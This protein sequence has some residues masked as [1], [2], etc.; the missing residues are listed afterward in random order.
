[1]YILGIAGG[2]DPIHQNRYG[3]DDTIIHD[4]AAVLL[5][6]DDIIA[7]IEEERLNRIKHTNK[8]PAQ[9]IRFCLDRADVTLDE[10]DAVAFYATEE[11]L[12]ASLAMFHLH[13]P[14]LG[15]FV[16]ART[17]ILQL[18]EEEAGLRLRK[19]R[20]QFVPHHLAHALSAY[21]TSGFDDC[22]ILSIDGAGEQLS[23]LVLEVRDGTINELSAKGISDSLG[24]LYMDVIRFLGYRMYDEY[25]VMG[26]SPYGDPEPFRDLFQTFYTLAPDGDFTIHRDRILEL[27]HRLKPRKRGELFLQIHKD[28]AAALQESVEI[29]AFH[30][31]THHRMAAGLD[32]LALTGGVA[33]NSSMNGKII[34]SGLFR[35]VYVPPAAG[36]SGC[37]FGAAFAAYHKAKSTLPSKRLK[38]VY[39]GTHVGSND[40][41]ESELKRW[42]PLIRFS[43]MTDTPVETARRLAEGSVIGWVQGEAEFGP[44]ALG[45]RSIV[46][47]PRPAQNKEIINAMI[48]KR[49]AY[50][51]F[52]PSVLLERVKDFFET[53]AQGGEFPF[54]TSV[55][56]VREEWR[57]QLGAITHVDGSARLQTVSRED[58]PLY[59]NLI[60]AF[61]EITGVPIVLNTS[62][63]NN[64]E[65][66]VNTLR[67]AIVCFLTSGLHYLVAGDYFVEKTFEC[68]PDISNLVISLLPAA[69]LHHTVQTGRDGTRVPS[70]YIDWNYDRRSPYNLSESAFSVLHRVDDGKT[71]SDLLS[72][73]Q[74]AN[75][76]E[77]LKEIMEL[78]HRRFI[79]LS[80]VM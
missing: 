49:E 39:W 62:F 8:F 31:L 10:V 29:I 41:I 70:F 77:L 6:D 65:P 35:E 67:E 53:P 46:A 18:F 21:S 45:H 25:K 60:H 78:W 1:M 73:E 4:S 5:R 13:R 34:Q 43:R 50:R 72:E 24:F 27:Y 75:R 17:L 19:D 64:A 42:M 74:N 20:L 69:R 44:R 26:L 36:D 66:I 56:P 40:E 30:I 2:L 38:Q 48:K 16:D 14:E 68:D 59:W 47:D 12:N 71:V 61:G 51:P 9:S 55:L 57:A 23:V 32:C 79:R 52:A 37:A 3:T 28:I 63:N 58:A 76:A 7:G 33:Q 22:L 80:P 54:M 11:F 15:E